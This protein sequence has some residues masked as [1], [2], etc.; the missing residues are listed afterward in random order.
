[1]LAGWSL[2]CHGIST[3]EPHNGQSALQSRGQSVCVDVIIIDYKIA[4]F[5][6]ISHFWQFNGLKIDR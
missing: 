2:M 3:C 6:V 4:I 1:M 5:S